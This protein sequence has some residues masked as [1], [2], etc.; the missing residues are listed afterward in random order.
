MFSLWIVVTI[1]LRNPFESLHPV[2]KHSLQGLFGITAIISRTTAS[3]ASSDGNTILPRHCLTCPKRQKS[4]G[5][6]SGEYSGCTA[7]R[8]LFFVQKACH[9]SPSASGRTSRQAFAA[10]VW[11]S[12]Y[13][14][15]SYTHAH[16]VGQ[17]WWEYPALS[18][19]T[20]SV[21][22]RAGQFHSK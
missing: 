20:D 12:S 3:N 1:V 15:R 21:R 7:S 6:R 17:P 14:E 10:T 5:A 2:V 19:F 4:D 13:P 8:T 22:T 9:G 18:I 16:A 11:Q